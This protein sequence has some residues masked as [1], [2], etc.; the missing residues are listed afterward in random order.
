MR[1]LENIVQSFLRFSRP[2]ALNLQRLDPAAFMRRVWAL[3]EPEARERQLRL[4]LELG[5]ALP[6]VDADEDQLSQ[7]LLNV[8][9]NAFQASPPG[10]RIDLSCRAVGDEVVLAVG[11][12]GH[13][14]PAGDR[15]R[16]FELYFTT[17]EEGTGLGLPIAQRIVHQHG[18]TLAVE[19]TQGQGTQVY[20]RLPAAGRVAE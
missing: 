1:R 4:E 15:G 18:G 5:D 16:I 3:V 14:I 7:A 13:G 6:G 9:I 20:L 2:P 17:R 10:A 19:S 12:H 11:D 8:L